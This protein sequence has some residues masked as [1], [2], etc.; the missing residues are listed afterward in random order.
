MSKHV[1]RARALAPPPD[2]L[3]GRQRELATARELFSATRL[4]TL[5]GPGG[6][7]KTT[8]SAALSATLDRAFRDGTWFVELGAQRSSDTV[9]E[10]VV[11]QLGLGALATVGAEEQL[12][13]HV[14]DR[15]MLLILDNCEH[16][17]P[18]CRRLVSALLAASTELRVLTTSRE[19][20]GIRGERV[21]VVRPLATPPSQHDVTVDELRQY[22]AVAMLEARAKSVNDQ[23]EITERT[24]AAVSRL[25]AKLDGMPLAIELAAV[26]LRS[27]SV[28]ELLAHIDDRFALLTSGDPTTAAHHQ[29]L[30]A[31]VRWSYDLCSPT[32]QLLWERMAVFSGSADLPAIEAVCGLPPLE[33]TKLL[34]ALD[35]LVS[36]SIVLTETAQDGMR[37]RFLETLRE[38]AREHARDS[39]DYGRARRAHTEYYRTWATRA[40]ENFFGPDQPDIVQRWESDFTNL[41]LAFDDLLRA[42]PGSHGALELAAN[43]RFSWMS[44]HLREGR[45][46]LERA[47]ASDATACAERGNALWAAGWFEALHG[48]TRTALGFLDEAV[49]I[50]REISDPRMAARAATWTG[51]T[52]MIAG[53]FEACRSALEAAYTEHRE[54]ADAEGLLMTLFLLGL[55]KSM[56]GDHAGATAAGREALERSERVGDTWGRSYSQWMLGFDA[57]TCQNLDV[58]EE[59]AKQSLTLRWDYHDDFG[60]AVVL[61]LLAGIALDNGDPKKAAKLL[62]VVAELLAII[63]TEVPGML[64]SRYQE[65]KAAT[66]DRLGEDLFARQHE[67][68][69]RLDRGQRMRLA[70]GPAATVPSDQADA[71]A[72]ASLL[73][74]REKEVATLLADGLSNRAIAG[75]LVL[76]PR[77]V[78]AHVEHILA[79]LSVNSRTEA[80]LWAANALG[81]KL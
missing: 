61:Y 47:L 13:R 4:V 21:V 76:S 39:D 65:I 74:P 15:S 52:T 54:H 26:R 2:E 51:F 42:A 80:G 22:P 3:F 23:F 38:F 31:L 1:S 49:A 35:G 5:T 17:L 71:V 46:W 16:V 45:R 62:G 43:L 66:R 8:L 12:R 7:G 48:E 63:D 36:K 24:T 18:G 67:I 27:L 68:G 69:R 25:C 37:Y 77:T 41:E 59:Y 50:A 44:G 72:F 56:S 40:A 78:E 32:E 64:G 75:K 10:A 73:T 9:A 57:W 30:D 70:L 58:A 19:P 20:L 60:S 29:S 79:K 6:V 34:D 14:A 53:D 55:V 81:R 28:Q 11:T 33:G